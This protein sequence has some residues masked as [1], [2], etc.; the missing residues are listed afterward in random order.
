MHLILLIPLFFLSLL[1]CESVKEKEVGPETE[2]VEAGEGAEEVVEDETI[3]Q[4]GP[5]VNPNIVNND[6]FTSGLE[7]KE[8]GNWEA[9]ILDFSEAIRLNP[10]YE[11]AYTE[12]AVAFWMLGLN[13]KAINDC[14]IAI[15]INPNYPK[16]YNIRAYIKS[17]IGLYFCDDLKRSCELDDENG[18]T[19]FF[20]DGCC[21]LESCKNAGC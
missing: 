3:P 12:R 15:G 11:E 16:A 17:D 1:S 13:D 14:S 4:L 18:Y 21:E 20:L 8:R 7:N 2:E 5:E 9:S 10:D 6:A 19:Y